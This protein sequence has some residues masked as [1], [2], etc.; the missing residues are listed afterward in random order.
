L[1]ERDLAQNVENSRKNATGDEGKLHNELPNGLSH[2]TARLTTFLSQA[3]T[4]AGAHYDFLAR[5]ED[6]T[7]GTKPATFSY[8]I[9]KK[10]VES[11]IAT[12][13]GAADVS[14]KLK[15][16]ALALI[17]RDLAQN[18]ENSRKNAI[19]DEGKL[20]NEL[21]NGLSYPTARLTTFLSQ[22]STEAGAHYDFLARKENYAGGTKPTT[23]SYEIRKKFVESYIATSQAAADVSS[24]LKEEAL[25]LIER[26]LAQNVEN[27]RRSARATSLS[28][29]PDTFGYHWARLGL[30]L[31]ESLMYPDS[32]LK[33][34]VNSAEEQL[35]LQGK[36][37]GTVGQYTLTLNA[38]GEAFLPREVDTILF[39]S[40]NGDPK[41]IHDRYN[42]WLR[43]G[44]G[45]RELDDKWREGAVDR[46]EAPDPSDNNLLKRKYFFTLPDGAP[47]VVRILAKKRFIPH[48][49]DSEKMYLQNAPAIFEAAK[50]LMLGGDQIAPHFANAI[51]LL[52]S[53]VAQ[54]SFKGD[55]PFKRRVLAML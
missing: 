4:E 34:F 18:V 25:A 21:P 33:R 51:K 32:A 10:Y 5:K 20:H 47:P 22:A 38:S 35:M 46:G 23:F 19:G 29:S 16:E 37:V 54:Q 40:F 53:Q 52:S 55:I 41:P 28:G 43:G 49:S 31:P 14:S 36:W 45:Y 39:L 15:E 42:E 26:D 24:K 12:S 3:S 50:G 13:Q 30:D 6:Y 1:I 44:T 9:R 11:Y 2:P 48:T 17:E 7:G 8:E 27:T